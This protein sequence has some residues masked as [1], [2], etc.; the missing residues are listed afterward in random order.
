MIAL[1]VDCSFLFVNVP[2]YQLKDKTRHLNHGNRVQPLCTVITT[3][4]IWMNT[5]CAV[6]LANHLRTVTDASLPLKFVSATFL[7]V[8]FLSLNKSTCQT[9]RNSFYFTSK[10]LFVLEKIKF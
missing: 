4:V 5:K 7:L 9:R 1:L 6:L 2:K 8:C 10:A 3:D